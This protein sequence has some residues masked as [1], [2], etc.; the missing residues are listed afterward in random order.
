MDA[1]E[2]LRYSKEHEW[3]NPENP[4]EAAIGITD[5]AQSQLGDVV[6]LDL[7]VKVGDTLEQE[8]T[9]ATVESV[10]AVSE[11]YSPVSGKVVEINQALVD[12]PEVL[13]TDPYGEGWLVKVALAHPDEVEALMNGEDYQA[14]VKDEDAE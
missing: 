9:F 5:Y 4:K 14:F 12:T 1:P 10:K 11:I 6:Y 3:I 7:Q 2:Q 13:N 8:Q